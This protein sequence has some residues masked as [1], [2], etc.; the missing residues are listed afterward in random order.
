MLPLGSL[1]FISL[2]LTTGAFVG[3]ACF[4]RCIFAPKS[5]IASMLVILGLGGVL[6]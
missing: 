1:D 4:A 6:I 3:V 5:A 2:S